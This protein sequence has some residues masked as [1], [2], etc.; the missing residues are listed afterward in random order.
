M[1][2]EGYKTL[3]VTTQK[4]IPKGVNEV[5]RIEAFMPDHNPEKSRELNVGQP[6]S[7]SLLS[8]SFIY[9]IT[10]RRHVYERRLP[11]PSFLV[12]GIALTMVLCS[13][14]QQNSIGSAARTA[15]PENRVIMSVT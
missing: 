15:A 1:V 6:G 14:Q 4:K 3:L 8:P 11:F 13:R 12:F 9:A 5:V 2:G 10:S 7:F